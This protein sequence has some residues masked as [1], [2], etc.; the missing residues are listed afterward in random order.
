MTGLTGAAIANITNRLLGERLILRPALPRLL[1]S[2]RDGGA[3]RRAGRR[4]QVLP[5]REWPQR[6]DRLAALARGM[7]RRDAAAADR[8]AVGGVCAPRVDRRPRFLATGPRA[9]RCGWPADRRSVDTRVDRGP[10]R[11]VHSNQLPDQPRG[12]T[13]RRAAA[14]GPP[15]PIGGGP[16]PA[17]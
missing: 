6:R 17:G 10:R 13:D 2:P 8:V 4:R 9:S 15:P 16:P 5:R 7:R 12:D 3:R 11:V 1:L 14:G